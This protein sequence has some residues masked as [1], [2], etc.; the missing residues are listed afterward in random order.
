[1]VLQVAFA[2]EAHAQVALATLARRREL[3][4]TVERDVAR[5]EET[6]LPVIDIRV[7]RENEDRVLTLVRG[8]HGIVMRQN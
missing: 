3:F 6:H 2:S 8:M 7:P 1:M 5:S 4:D